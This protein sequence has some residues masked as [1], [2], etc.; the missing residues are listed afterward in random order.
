MPNN[1]LQI[2]A[3]GEVYAQ[4]L[5]NEAQKQGA[6]DQ[7]TEDVRGIGG[8]L[9]SNEAFIAFTRS[10]MVD[11]DE[12]IAALEKIFGQGRVHVLTLSTLKSLA[13]RELFMFLRGVVESFETILKK[14]SGHVDVELVSSAELGPEVVERVKLAI[15]KS[16]GQVADVKVTI[17]P[18]LIGGM[19][20]RV[21]D[22]LI[23]GS[24]A[25][26]LGK[27]EEQLKRKGVSALQKDLA[28]V[29]A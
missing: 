6:L 29:I 7:V 21:G 11:Q 20:L 25:T 27:L 5:I 2:E 12:R 4:A 17:N 10:L 26:Q 23:D 16:V 22:T 18:A 1:D 19:T 14:M 8:L 15:G 24:V 3:I 13:R 28:A 9:K